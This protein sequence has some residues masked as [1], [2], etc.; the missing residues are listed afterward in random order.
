MAQPRYTQGSGVAEAETKEL[1]NLAFEVDVA[2][3]VVLE[4][5][6]PEV[7]KAGTDEVALPA[8]KN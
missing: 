1:E 2:I 7:E 5:I 8:V 3:V 4:A 6:E